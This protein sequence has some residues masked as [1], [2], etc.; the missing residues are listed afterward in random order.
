VT[1]ATVKKGTS[2]LYARRTFFFDEDSWQILVVD[3][4]DGRG[5]IWRVQETYPIT[6]YEKPLIFSTL[7]SVYDLQNGRYLSVG[8]NNEGPI[9]DFDYQLTPEDFTPS[10]LRREGRR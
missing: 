1:E 7:E 3:C 4:Y 9:E 10:A 6:F 5:Q 8:F 2:H